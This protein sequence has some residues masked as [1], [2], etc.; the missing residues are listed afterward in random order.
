MKNNNI[1]IPSKTQMKY[2]NISVIA[3]IVF[4]LILSWWGITGNHWYIPSTYL[5][6][7]RWVIVFV[8]YCLMTVFGILPSLIRHIKDIKYFK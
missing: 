4:G 8:V 1:K 5:E 7:T 3:I 6:D 2:I